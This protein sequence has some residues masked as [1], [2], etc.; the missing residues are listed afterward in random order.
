MLRIL[1]IA[2]GVFTWGSMAA[3]AHHLDQAHAAAVTWNLFVAG[4]EA[5]LAWG[6]PNS[7]LVGIMMTCQRGSNAVLVSGDVAADRPRLV[8]ASGRQKLTLNGAAEPD[9]YTGGH[10]MEARAST[11][12]AALRRFARTGD[13]TL[14]K[15]LGSLEMQASDDAKG[16]IRRF[17]AHCEA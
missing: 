4:S 17:F 6:Q 5:K 10:W 8:L 13:L 15:R 11:G 9:P 2:L 7:D 12:E 1:S 14:V 3:C 16:D